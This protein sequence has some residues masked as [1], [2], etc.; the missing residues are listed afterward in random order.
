MQ[1]KV[2][3]S[4]FSIQ[5]HTT[6]TTPSPKLLTIWCTTFSMTINFRKTHTHG[7]LSLF[8]CSLIFKFISQE[9]GFLFMALSCR[10]QH[11]HAQI[12]TESRM[13]WENITSTKKYCDTLHSSVGK[14][15]KL[16]EYSAVVLRGKSLGSEKWQT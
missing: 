16:I 5:S 14:E 11:I 10:E 13:S 2:T 15:R 7:I 12:H 3:V 6:T 1:K 9:V 4:T 8:F